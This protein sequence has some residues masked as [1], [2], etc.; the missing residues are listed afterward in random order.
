MKQGKGLYKY[1]SFI[2]FFLLTLVIWFVYRYQEDYRT[3]LD[4]K[5][6][7]IN[8]PSDIELDENSIH[9]VTT[10]VYGTGYFLLYDT[11]FDKEITMDFN[12][13]V[14][15]KEEAFVI[16]QSNLLKQLELNLDDRYVVESAGT[17]NMR[18]EFTRLTQKKIPVN[19]D[20]IIEFSNGLSMVK[21]GGLSA[22]S[23]LVI[24]AKRLIDS[25]DVIDVPSQRLIVSDTSYVYRVK[26]PAI[27]D[28]INIEPKELIYALKADYFTEARFK[29]KVVVKD[30]PDNVAVKVMPETIEM[31]CS[32]PLNDFDQVNATLFEAYVPYESLFNSENIIIPE[33]EVLTSLIKNWRIEPK[34]LKVLVIK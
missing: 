6:N 12:T 20:P 3:Q 31:V 15:L 4:I 9:I 26:I 14:T 7:W 21:E 5:I 28:K 17:H 23:V 18:L 22:D 33:I 13:V 8:I 2:L 11:Y 24:G 1:G 29:L 30:L 19:F 32:V 10:T 25:I 34:Q 27:N 16:N